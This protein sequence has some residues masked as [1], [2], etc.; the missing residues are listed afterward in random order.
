MKEKPRA[1]VTT[2][3]QV[4][5]LYELQLEKFFA[6]KLSCKKAEQISGC[7]EPGIKYVWVGVTRL[8][9]CKGI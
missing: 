3:F 8:T 9:E 6:N 1:H 7:L 5:N 2:P 4:T